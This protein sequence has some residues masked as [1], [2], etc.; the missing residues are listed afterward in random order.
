MNTRELAERAAA[1]ITHVLREIEG[2]PARIVIATYDTREDYEDLNRNKSE[3]DYSEHML[4]IRLCAEILAR[5][6]ASERIVFQPIGAVEYWKW[7]ALHGY[8]DGRQKRAAF[9][10]EKY[11]KLHDAKD[12]N[13]R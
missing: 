1:E 5:E 4:Y 3:M 8:T 10:S 7:L 6:N 11:G 13:T 9:A 12:K 2:T